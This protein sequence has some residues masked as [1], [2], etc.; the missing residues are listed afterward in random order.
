MNVL[1]LVGSRN[2][3]GRTA[4]SAAALLK[5]VGEAGGNGELVMLIEKNLERCRM[6]DM[7]G[8]GQCRRESSCV[9][10]DDFAALLRRLRSADAIVFATPVYFSDL[11]EVM[12]AFLNRLRR[13]CMGAD[14][15]QGIT[16]KPAI[17]ICMAGGGGGGA[18]TC[19][20]TMMRVLSHC[21]FDV[22]DMIPVRRQN[23]EMKQDVLRT[24]G[25]WLVSRQ[26]APE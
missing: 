18:P 3:E 24:V 13:V 21:D 2:P 23:M 22:L 10:D 11:S 19:A 4:A 12:H 20:A 17:G 25:R 5:G 6:C 7:D 1:A 26:G 14:G 9:I 8:W 15:K 16:G